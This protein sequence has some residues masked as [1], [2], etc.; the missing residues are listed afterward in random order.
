MGYYGWEEECDV[1]VECEACKA[2]ENTIENLKDEA[3]T[4]EKMVTSILK[5]LY[6]T[7][8]FDLYRLESEI[9]ELCYHLDIPTIE[10]DLQIERKRLPS[11][12]SNLIELNK[13]A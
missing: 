7:E 1:A 2:L 11:F 13:I 8:K 5:M 12:F 10:G 3:A 4:T 9:D 6:S